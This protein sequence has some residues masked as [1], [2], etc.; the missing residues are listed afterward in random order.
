MPREAF[1]HV[2]PSDHPWADA[3]R[4]A[5]GRGGGTLG[6]LAESEAVVWLDARADAVIDVLHDRVRWLQFRNAGVDA[7]IDAGLIDDRRV[8]TAARG[9]YAGGVAEHALTLILASLGGLRDA[10]RTSPSRN[11]TPAPRT[12][13]GLTVAIVG[14]GGIGTTLAALLRPFG[15][16]IVGVTRTGRVV[17]D[18]DVSLPADRLDE[19]WPMA[20]VVVLCAPATPATVGLVDRE[21]LRAM[22]TDAI[23]VNVARG[24]L[25]D[26]DALVEALDGGWIGGAAL[27]V[28]TPEPLPDDHPLWRE[29]R[30]IITPHSANP[31]SAQRG[32]LCEM[33]TEN[34]RRFLAGEELLG[35]VD[36]EAGY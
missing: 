18:C 4:E 21:V 22:R 23:L 8:F 27:D 26:T 19:V 31:S 12:L 2:A 9:I 20:D 36:R 13:A 33:V 3:A 15:S 1:V 30:A 32:L 5:V 14:A 17:P 10:V 16:R 7:L 35:V 24:T 29:P 25:V 6:G 28:T 11:A 34:V